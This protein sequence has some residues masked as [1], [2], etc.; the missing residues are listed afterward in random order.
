MEIKEYEKKEINP[1]TMS[2]GTSLTD[3]SPLLIL[4][5]DLD[6]HARGIRLHKLLRRTEIIAVIPTQYSVNVVRT[7]TASGSLKTRLNGESP[8]RC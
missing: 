3:S 8:G 4:R 2:L 1:L 7:S 5:N 6:I